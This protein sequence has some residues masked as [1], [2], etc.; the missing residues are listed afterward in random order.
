MILD[1]V[2][3]KTKSD[4]PRRVKATTDVQ[5]GQDCSLRGQHGLAVPS[6]QTWFQK[7][8]KWKAT[9]D[10]ACSKFQKGT[11]SRQHVTGSASLQDGPKGL[12]RDTKW[13]LRCDRD[14]RGLEMPGTWRVCQR[15]GLWVQSGASPRERLCVLQTIE[16]EVTKPTPAQIMLQVP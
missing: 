8:G 11:K 5:R 9:E 2:K 6:A 15:K 14:P 16:L 13:S 4:Y 12:S 10:G 7:S 3:L 1:C